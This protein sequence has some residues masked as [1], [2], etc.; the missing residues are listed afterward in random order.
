[1]SKGFT[2]L[3]L[4]LAVT[5]LGIIMLLLFSALRMGTTSW[6][7]VQ[8]RAEATEQQYL[9]NRF[10]TRELGG[11]VP[12]RGPQRKLM[13]RGE[14]NAVVFVSEFP[15]HRGNG[16]LYTVSLGEK[17]RADGSDLVYRFERLT[18]TAQWPPLLVDAQEKILVEDIASID[19][20]YLGRT[21][22]GR[23]QDW[24]ETW[25]QSSY[26][27][28]LIRLRYAVVDQPSVELYVP[29]RAGSR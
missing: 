4:L 28:A 21:I 29:V 18:E 3:E 14:E 15:P 11:A 9:L 1:M 13:F 22:P 19:I 17:T 20:A 7:G 27:P 23:P 10:L 8:Q 12:V 26:P 24:S 5:L 25:H 16:G 6:R 2:L